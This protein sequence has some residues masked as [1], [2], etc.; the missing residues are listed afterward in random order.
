[1][2]ELSPQARELV[3]ALMQQSY[4]DYMA[5]TSALIENLTHANEE[6]RAELSLIRENTST[7][8]SGPFMPTT[9]H[10]ETLLWPSCD[11]ILARVEY[12]RPAG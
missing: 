5:T 11:E 6:M 7:L 8:L 2:E 4:S 3:T 10:L 9:G 12:D 1:M